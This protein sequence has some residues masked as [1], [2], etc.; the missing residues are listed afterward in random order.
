MSTTLRDLQ[1]GVIQKVFALRNLIAW[2]DAVSAFIDQALTSNPMGIVAINGTTLSN[3]QG[4]ASSIAFGTGVRDVTL[5]TAIDTARTI[6]LV[7][8]YNTAN[9]DGG[10]SWEWISTT[11]CRVRTTHIVADVTTPVN[12][13]FSITFR[14]LAS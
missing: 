14:T 9:W 3:N 8:V 5:T 12:V 6:A 13:P 1:V 4:I 2:F 10:I 11:V 7:S